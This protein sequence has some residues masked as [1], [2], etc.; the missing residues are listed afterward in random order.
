[1]ANNNQIN[2]SEQLQLLHELNYSDLHMPYGT[3]SNKATRE[4]GTNRE[5]RF[6]DAIAAALT[7]GNPGD[8]FAAAFDKRGHVEVVLAKNGPL[9]PEDIAAAN[10]LMSLIGDPTVAES[11]AAISRQHY[12]HTYQRLTFGLSF[13]AGVGECFLGDAETSQK[14]AI[15]YLRADALGRS[16]F[17]NT[18]IANCGPLEMDR[19]G[20]LEKLER[21]L[22]KVCQ[23]VSG[24]SELI[25]GAKKMLPIRHRWVTDTFTG[26]GEGVFHLCDSPHDAVARGLGTALSEDIVNKLHQDFP[27]ILSNWRRRQTV[28]LSCPAPNRGQQAKLHL[29][30]SVD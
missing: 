16:R 8:V 28:H 19:K 29:L 24:I 26:S 10:E 30:C 22:G 12:R 21:R 2:L 1:M 23:Y 13:L 9:T 17:L 11:S 20:R 7:T 4:Y 3:H 27:F 18:L 6:L 5:V 15:L 25:Q 14:Y